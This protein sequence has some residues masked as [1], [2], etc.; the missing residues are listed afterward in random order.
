MV[1]STCTGPSG[2]NA[3]DPSSNK[4]C[5]GLRWTWHWRFKGGRLGG[6]G[7]PREPGKMVVAAPLVVKA[8]SSCPTGASAD[9]YYL[10]G[11]NAA[12]VKAGEGD[13]NVVDIRAEA[14]ADG[15]LLCTFRLYLP[16]SGSISTSPSRSWRPWARS[17]PRDRCASTTD[18]TAGGQLN[19]A[20]GTAFRIRSRNLL[21]KVHGYIMV[22]SWGILIPLGAMV[23]ASL[24]R[25][26][27]L[28]FQIHRVVQ[29]IAYLAA[30]VGMGI[31]LYMRD[32][33]GTYEEYV[34]RV[35]GLVVMGL[36]LLQV[37]ALLLRPSKE[38]RFAWLWSGYHQFVGVVAI[39][40]AFTNAILGMRN[41]SL[42]YGYFV[43][44]SLIWLAILGFWML[45][46][47]LSAR[48]RKQTGARLDIQWQHAAANGMVDE[49]QPELQ[50]G[51]IRDRR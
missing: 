1:P 29:S 45:G 51:S 39:L 31:G 22:I 37:M 42:Y 23:A 2:G 44:F 43:G 10:E 4:T 30:I 32:Y 28:W 26:D 35:V 21:P 16:Y 5:H 7:L 12:Q 24:K 15:R 11:M 47:C 20:S 9:N 25:F 38:H 6:F 50:M 49:R 8:C 27:P 40:L 46:R 33:L 17:P 14:T 18:S 48:H 3:A 36:G 19:F 34:H 13:L 41:M